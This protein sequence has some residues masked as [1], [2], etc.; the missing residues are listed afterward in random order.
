MKRVVLLGTGTNVGKTY[1]GVAVAH[2]MRR[3]GWAVRAIKP[4]ES[5]GVADARALAA[6]TGDGKFVEPRYGFVN[7][8]SP[9]L[10]AR[11]EGK[12]IELAAVVSWVE[13]QSAGSDWCI[14]ETAGGVL[15]PLGPGVT[16]FDL[17]CALDPAVWILVAPD[18]LGVLNGLTTTLTALRALGRVPDLCV[19]STPA[20]PDAST[21]SNAGEIVQ[22]G[23]A[24]LAAIF[25]RAATPD[26]SAAD[27]LTA[28]VHESEQ[29]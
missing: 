29:S 15:T 4:V 8:V 23:I 17:A 18:S 25:P 24:R 16:N 14:I 12:P 13:E 7:P 21:G 1:V 19:L 2:A 5:G 11:I 3:R 9:H 6:A 10:A 20:E 27:V 26:D 22:L 28:A